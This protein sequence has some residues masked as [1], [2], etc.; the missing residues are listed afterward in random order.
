MDAKFKVD[1]LAEIERKL[2]QLPQRVGTNAMRRS[3]RKGANVVRDAA[4]A[5]AKRIDDPET[6]EQI[7]KNIVV[8][9]GGRKREKLAGGPMMRVGVLGGARPTSEDNG[10]PGGN[11]TH[12]RFIELGTSQAAA[13][14]FMR[15]AMNDKAQAAFDAIAADALK[16]TDRE[17]AKLR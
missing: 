14:P 6:R 10:A 2:K 8:Q 3:L 16:Q 17:L 1:G 4:R 12:W 11:T 5:N 9:S 7:A 15:P 13:Q